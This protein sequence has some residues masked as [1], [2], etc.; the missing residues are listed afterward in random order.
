MRCAVLECFVNKDIKSLYRVH[1]PKSFAEVIGQE[2]ITRTL[3]NQIE[4]G[5]IGHAYL[6]C[7]TR[8]TGKTSVAKIFANS[9][10]CLNF[11]DGNVCGS[12]EYCKKTADGSL[13]VFE[14]DA[15]SNNR[16]EDVRDLI[17]KV[18]YPPVFG[19]YKVYIVDEVHMFSQSAFNAFL[20]TLEE[21]PSHV[22]FVLAT[23]E[24]HK[25]LPTVQSRC[26]RFDFRTASTKEIE[27]L[28][29][30][31]FAKEKIKISAEAISLIAK[32][33]QGSFRDALSFADMVAAYTGGDITLD[34]INTVLGAVSQEVLE[35]LLSSVCANDV[36]K[37]IEFC[38]KIYS[39]GRNANSVVKDFLEVIKGAYV[40]GGTEAEDCIEVYKVLAETELNI[41]TATDARAMF[42]GACL[43]AAATVKKKRKM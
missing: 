6:F 3:I 23:T 24:A 1:R 36:K 4:R 7:G 10:N 43:L 21:P 26:L 13:D 30:D 14:I 41:K 8:G 22:I 29:S 27:K 39:V 12:C 19:R 37:I 33:G 32:C 31:V 28:L 20:K 16:V 11:K 25:L 9:V 5:K 15:A 2:H 38:D 35:G 40:Q 18:K 34:A 17:E 42:E